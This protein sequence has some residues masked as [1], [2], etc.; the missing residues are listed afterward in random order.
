MSV[1]S[2][3]GFARVRR[4]SEAGEVVVSVKSVNHRGLDMH[5]HMPSALDVFENELRAAVKRFAARGHFQIHVAFS[6]AGTEAPTIVN[7]PLLNSYISAFRE[8]AAEQGIGG[9]PDLN[10]ALSLPGMLREMGETEP[11]EG[12]R[13]LLVSAA[14]EALG[15]LNDFREREG[16]EIAAELLERAA[17]VRERAARMEEIR[18]SALAAFQSRLTERLGELLQCVNLEPQRIVQE[19][20]VLADRSDIGEELVRLKI[21]AGQVEDLLRRGGEI[22]KKMDFLLQE[23][24]REANTVLS[25]TGGIGELG[26]GI[27]ELALAAK[28]DIEKIREQSLNLE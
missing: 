17:A 21:H 23:M 24:N 5:F 13:S 15:A 14:E 4:S 16:R 27:T 1:R 20:A 12:V 8:A 25:K 11:D 2:M 9:E 18:S 19:A 6:P 26:F 22:G 7:R 10:A 28:S 3:T